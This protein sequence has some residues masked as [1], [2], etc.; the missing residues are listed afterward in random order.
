MKDYTRNLMLRPSS[1]PPLPRDE[2]V[3]PADAGAPRVSDTATKERFDRIAT[4]ARR[5]FDMPIALLTLV[6]DARQRVVSVQGMTVGEAARGLSFCAYTSLADE[7]MVAPDTRL[8]RRFA[9]HPLVVG[10]PGIRYYA[11]QALHGPQGQPVGTLCVLD[12]C[13]RRLGDD[14]LSTLRDLAAWAE[15]ELTAL[16]HE[17]AA[18]LRQGNDQR[19]RAI[20]DSVPDGIVTFDDQG[21][22]TSFNG[23]AERIFG[24]TARE[25]LGQNVELLLPTDDQD[26]VVGNGGRSE[27]VG[28]R[29]DRTRFPIELA[30]ND[31]SLGE[32]RLFITVMRDIT[33]R[34]ALERELAQARDRALETSRLKSEF[35]AT[36]SHEIRTPMNGVIGMTDLLLTTPL[37]EEQREFAGVVRD[38]AD[39]LLGII[40]EILDFSKIEAGKIVLDDAKVQPVVVVEAV[41]ELLAPKAREK[42]IALLSFIAPDIPTL[43]RGDPG[44]L[45]QILLNLVGNA[46]KFTEQGEVV[47]TVTHEPTNDVA[48]HADHA[49]HP[50]VLLR[51]AV[52]DTGIGLSDEARQRLFQPFTQ[53]DGS[54]T[55]RYGGTG[56]GLAISRRLAELMGG[57]IGVQSVEGVGSTFWFT[58]RL[59]SGVANVAGEAQASPLPAPDLH[60]GHVLVVD[61]Q[62]THRDIVIRYLESWGLQAD[63]VATA[64]D[65]FAR[66]HAAA[67]DGEPY[68]V[69]VV[70]LMMPDADGFALLRMV[71]RDPVLGRTQLILLTAFDDR[72]QREQAL[73]AG[74]AAY[75]AKPVKRAQLLAAIGAAVTD[76][77]ATDTASPMP[78]P[79]MDRPRAAAADDR[80]I[81]LADDTLTGRQ[82]AIAHL[83][84]LGYLVDAVGD[85]QAA[86]DGIAAAAAAG[87]PYALALMDWQMP[88]LDGLGATRAIRSAE[89]ATGG[90]IPI[91]GLTANAMVGDREGCLGAGMDDYLSKPLRPD[92]LRAVLERWLPGASHDGD[93]ALPGASHDGDRARP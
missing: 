61:D 56:L 64:R 73:A 70:D 78:S 6:D 17:R 68:D 80:M 7:T 53:A 40:D 39:T 14:D 92:A 77:R 55:R 36:M 75:V 8:D 43:L 76:T 33:E 34:K 60:D 48:G 59:A 5:L 85:G 41:C 31:I 12:L 72:G 20:M 84:R 4:L 57:N 74:F 50:D 58:A 87:R 26:D 54:T 62:P 66:L 91:I 63:A 13:P 71:Q 52:T 46:V 44:R 9:Q 45:R 49:D 37:D 28:R 22:I 65:A 10:A 47:V 11:G 32:Q 15:A 79:A 23:S 93:R 83:D 18:R 38:S 69:A 90:H 2:D 86:V 88:V 19:L 27:L 16:R 24:Y 30:A 89:T 67:R 25:V 29:R 35:L 21:L 42:G 81:L 1:W 51:V 82:V 3:Q